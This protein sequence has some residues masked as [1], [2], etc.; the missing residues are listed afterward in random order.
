[1]ATIEQRAIIESVLAGFSDTVLLEL[2]AH[3][4]H[5]TE[6]LLAACKGKYRY[7]A[8]EPEPQ[9]TARLR[10]R[11]RSQVDLFA[12]AIGA[13]TSPVPFYHSEWNSWSS[14][15]IRKPKEHLKY[16][17]DCVFSGTPTVDCFT[18]DDLCRERNIDHVDFIWS[19]IQGAE[20]DM[21]AGGENTLKVTRYLFM[22]FD[23]IEMY[24]GQA[25]RE[26]ILALLPGWETVKLFEFDILL[27]NKAFA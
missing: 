18:L 27:R 6:W 4:G 21:I 13:V 1:M 16:F 24:E 26:T 19:D 12:G 2:G 7:I 22:E 23:D 17:P 14:G 15:S 3:H 20:R 8:V 25:N 10:A 9:N 5:D 11:F